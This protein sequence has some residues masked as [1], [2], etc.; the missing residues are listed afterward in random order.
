MYTIIKTIVIAVAIGIRSVLALLAFLIGE[1][2]LRL[3]YSRTIEMTDPNSAE[4]C[5]R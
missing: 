2:G 4:V 3:D 1:A 5:S